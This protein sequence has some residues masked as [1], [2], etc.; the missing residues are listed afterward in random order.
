MKNDI[1]KNGK[2]KKHEE[3]RNINEYA[4]TFTR[5]TRDRKIMINFQKC[6]NSAR[7]T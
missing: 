3:K 4:E 7:L 1:A 6:R 5:L 2:G